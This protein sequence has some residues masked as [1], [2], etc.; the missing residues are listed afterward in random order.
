MVRTDSFHDRFIV[1]DG[2]DA[3]HVGASIKDAGK[4]AFAVSRIGDP[5]IVEGLLS[6]I[7]SLVGADPPGST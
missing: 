3:Y 7:A 4:R 2:T 6:R 1:L 5:V